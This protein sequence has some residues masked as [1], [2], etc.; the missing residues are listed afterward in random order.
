MCF[1][2]LLA[3]LEVVVEEVA[4]PIAPAAALELGVATSAEARDDRLW[5]SR[6]KAANK[7]DCHHYGLTTVQ[8]H[9]IYII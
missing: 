2:A 6:L 7:R 9:I 5:P 4:P 1:L 8:V 3:L